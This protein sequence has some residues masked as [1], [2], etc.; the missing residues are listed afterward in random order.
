MRK[1]LFIVWL[2][3]CA[4]LAQA[5]D[6]R[7]LV[8]Y[9]P[10]TKAYFGG[11]D[12]TT[13]TALAAA[14][15]SMNTALSNSASS[16]TVTYAGAYLTNASYSTLRTDL[17]RTL[18]DVGILRA[19][20]GANADMVITVTNIIGVGPGGDSWQIGGS[21][22]YDA[23]A[24]TDV[25]YMQTYNTIAH[26]LGH[27]VGNHHRYIE[28]PSGLPSIWGHGFSSN[29]TQSGAGGSATSCFA[30]L[31]SVYIP[32]CPGGGTGARINY[33]SNP[34]VSISGA[35]GTS[36]PTGSSSC[37]SPFGN[38]DCSNAAAIMSAYSSVVTGFHLTKL[39]PKK[40]SALAVAAG[41]F[42]GT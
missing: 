22:P 36:W 2:A 29:Y 28:D 23:F 10:E 26:E 25:V 11:S 24:I 1:V 15:G 34:A 9:T 6:M 33:Y 8:V 39:A 4:A 17:F 35:L 7:V 42:D 37:A 31:M 19:R 27:V 38:N 20:D 12:A 18:S 21:S 40:I 5:A 13:Q 14:V 32:V 16:A 3:L 41:F 30:D